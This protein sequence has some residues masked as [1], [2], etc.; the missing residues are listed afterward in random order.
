[1]DDTG[2]RYRRSLW[3]VIQQSVLQRARTLACAGV[4]G[5][6]RWLVDD[7]DR[8]VEMHD[9][10]RDVLR[11][12]RLVALGLGIEFDAIAGPDRMARAR[13]WLL[14]EPQ[15][16]SL[17]PDLQTTA[18]ILAEQLGAGRLQAPALPGHGNPGQQ[19]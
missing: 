15:A 18:R 8:L 2:T 19:T 3:K 16:S 9:F 1:M 13:L 12:D 6:T 4:H 17:D 7:C 10:D 5:Q 14:V 11:L